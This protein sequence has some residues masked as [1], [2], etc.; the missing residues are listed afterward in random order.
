M[1]RKIVIMG[2]PGAGKT[3][4]A[5]A[6]VPLLNAVHFDPKAP[7]ALFIGPIRSTRATNA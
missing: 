5:K 1:K 3:T 7:T 4:L 2:L 6:L